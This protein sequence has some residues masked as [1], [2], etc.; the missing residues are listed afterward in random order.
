[1]YWGIGNMLP[2]T[3]IFYNMDCRIFDK[4]VEIELG[5]PY[6]QLLQ[7]TNPHCFNPITRGGGHKV[8]GLGLRLALTPLGSKLRAN[9]S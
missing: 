5:Y 1:M 4:Q 7:T 2:Y 9:A 3:G 8:P 6:S